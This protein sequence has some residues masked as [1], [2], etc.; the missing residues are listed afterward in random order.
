MTKQELLK[1]IDL[2]DQIPTLPS[3]VSTVL[4]LLSDP[5]VSANKIGEVIST[6][7]SLSTK[8][9]KI[10]NSAFYG[11][12]KRIS[13][14]TQ[15][16]VILGFNTIKS[17]VF[18]VAV[19]NAFDKYKKRTSINYEDF[20]NHSL[21]VGAASRVLSRYINYENSEEA[22]IGGIIHDIGKLLLSQFASKQYEE[23][24]EKVRYESDNK[25]FSDIEKSILG[26]D[27][28]EIGYFLVEKWNFPKNLSSIIKY[29]HNPSIVPDDRDKVLIS[30]IHIANII[31]K[32][33]GIGNS[34][35]SYV[36]K[37]NRESWDLL[38][39]RIEKLPNLYD[40]IK[41]EYEKTS[42]FLY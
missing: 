3:V 32:I 28:S 19:I 20:W 36:D 10:V 8:T 23:V 16:V 18:G 30:I 17:A 27:H 37:I 42:I 41:E 15:A 24:L 1:R 35:Y 13:T 2:Q 11:F 25:V 21:A 34:G 31:V 33:L 7:I 5:N 14:I 40:Q 29:H 12:S 38:G 26:F 4:N 9:L 39:L 22:F 6:D